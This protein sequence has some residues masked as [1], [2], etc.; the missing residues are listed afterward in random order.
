M[1][2]RL[3]EPSPQPPPAAEPAA[4]AAPRPRQADR[5]HRTSPKL[6]QPEL[7]LQVPDSR[8]TGAANADLTPLNGYLTTAMVWLSHCRQPAFTKTVLDLRGSY[9]PHA[10]PRTV[11]CR[12]VQR[13][14]RPTDNY[15]GLSASVT[16]LLACRFDAECRVVCRNG[17]ELGQ[18]CVS[19][20]RHVR[21]GSGYRG[22]IPLEDRRPLVDRHLD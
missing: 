15:H 9:L 3:R 21:P 1:M 5:A 11:I 7:Q 18:G 17:R 2:L 20:D 10:R 13:I 19:V 12:M 8:R 22:Q 6:V 16:R 4:H 14:A